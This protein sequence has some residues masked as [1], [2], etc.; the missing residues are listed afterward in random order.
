VTTSHELDLQVYKDASA[1][2]PDYALLC[3]LS[4]RQAFATV[5]LTS[6][7]E[8]GVQA[9]VKEISSDGNMLTVDIIYPI[10][11]MFLYLCPEYI[12]WMIQP[13][14]EYQS[15]GPL[16]ESC[17]HDL[18]SHYPY[19]TGPSDGSDSHMPVEESGNILIIA[20]AHAQARGDLSL[21][22]KYYHLFE[23]WTAFLLRKGLV[24]AE[25]LS[26]DGEMK[27]F[28]GYDARL[29][30]FLADFMGP[31]AN[32]SS[33][34]LKGGIGI[35]AMAEIA[36]LVGESGDRYANAAKLYITAWE[37]LATSRNHDRHL[38]LS[39]GNESSWMTAYNLY[40]EQ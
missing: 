15:K 29:I 2:S 37:K 7:P 18:G 28:Y 5:E 11:P 35:Q 12:G 4:L 36:R 21:L 22:Q 17:A 3:A 13:L 33:L 20:L 14:L 24:P 25:Q 19:A 1:V 38:M 40:A 39:Y 6:S 31:A 23:Q 26:T 8:R 16:Y 32:Q 34:A 10:L 27:R 30:S 9:W